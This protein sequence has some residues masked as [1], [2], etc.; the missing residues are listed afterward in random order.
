MNTITQF[1]AARRVSVPLIV[2]KSPDATATIN[3]IKDSLNGDAET[4]PLLQ[5]D[6]VRGI[7]AL[8]ERG[9]QHV[10]GAQAIGNIVEALVVME[11]MP[12]DSI[13]FVHN[14]HRYLDQVD[15]AQAVWNLRDTNKGDFKTLIL[16]APQ[17]VVPIELSNDVL[18]IDESLPDTEQLKQI[19]QAQHKNA[20]NNKDGLKVEKLT[21][22]VLTRAV[23]AISGLSAFAAEQSVAMSYERNSKSVL[24]LNQ[25][26]LW[27]RK[28]MAIEETRGLK[29]WRGGET[30]NDVGGCDNIKTFTTKLINGRKPPRAIVFI[31][32]IE[33]S[34]SG[35]SS[36]SNVA[37]SD[38][39]MVMLTEM[40]DKQAE[41]M[42][43][44]GHAGSAKSMIAKATGNTAGVPT[45]RFD[46]GGMM[47]SGLLGQAQ[48]EIRQAMKI[49]DS[50]S[51]GSALY[52][53]TCNKIDVIP[54][55][56]QRRFTLGTFFFDLP[57]KEERE[58]IWK[59]Y[60][61]RYEVDNTHG[62]FESDGWT[63]ADIHNCVKRA[64]MFKSTLTESAAYATPIIKTRPQQIEALRAVANGAFISASYGGIYKKDYVPAAS[65]A[66]Q[67]RS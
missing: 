65:K 39:L 51:Q 50:V 56:L 63:G 13:M 31:D 60:C 35:A 41:G 14:S 53:A 27:E 25:E 57:S 19:V 7:T 3:Q 67:F 43:F 16:L 11:G 15:A 32:E 29:V 5:W 46:L 1:K 22:E 34:I 48:N 26:Q 45:I 61:D 52:I 59:L 17:C 44:V 64:W 49:V 4:T 24:C 47:G 55:E 21:S 18:V 37:H 8:N 2:W 62:A 10:T 58:L 30:F 28:R 20:E 40:E 38:Q 6:F 36:D 66:R 54:P 23:D 42:L 12:E 33:K 9:A